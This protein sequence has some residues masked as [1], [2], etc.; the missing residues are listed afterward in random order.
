MSILDLSSSLNLHK[1]GLRLIWG[2]VRIGQI[3][4]K[5]SAVSIDIL[6]AF[7]LIRPAG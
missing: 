6:S 4:T 2:P 1:A 3:L 5:A 7:C